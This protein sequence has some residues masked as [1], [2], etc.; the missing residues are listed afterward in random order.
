LKSTATRITE[1]AAAKEACV[2]DTSAATALD[3]AFGND[4]S[5]FWRGGRYSPTSLES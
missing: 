2:L 4:E 3:A 5:T 1:L